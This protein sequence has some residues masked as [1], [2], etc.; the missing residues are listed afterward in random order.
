MQNEQH[1]KEKKPPKSSL[2]KLEEYLGP[3][4]SITLEITRLNGIN[5]G[6][7]FS[8]TEVK[9]YYDEEYGFSSRQNTIAAAILGVLDLVESNKPL[10]DEQFV[11]IALKIANNM[12]VTDSELARFKNYL[13]RPR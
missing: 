3:G 11:A 10:A 8:V 1:H 12:N 2:G 4:E 7:R 6:A 5:P 9:K 13:D